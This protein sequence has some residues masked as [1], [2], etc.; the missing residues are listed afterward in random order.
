MSYVQRESPRSLPELV[1]AANPSAASEFTATVPATEI[2]ELLSVTV[3]LVQGITQ[4]PHPSLVIDDG[5]TTVA[6]L[7]GSTGAQAASTTCQ[8]T[9]A[10]GVLTSAQIGVTTGVRSVGALPEALV[11]LPG[12][13]VASSTTGIGANSDYGVAI[14]N[15]I[16]TRN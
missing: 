2:W 16:K 11:L 13:R 9:W 15:V 10:K 3:A 8:Y 4:T 1:S 14:L 5:T 12:W 7:P 6:I